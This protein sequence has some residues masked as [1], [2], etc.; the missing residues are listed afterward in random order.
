MPE[1]STDE[2]LKKAMLRPK[3]VEVDNKVVESHD[4]DDLIAL[5]KYLE[6]KAAAKNRRLGIRFVRTFSGGGPQ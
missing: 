4:L 6:S 1:D 2:Q 3:R 5:D